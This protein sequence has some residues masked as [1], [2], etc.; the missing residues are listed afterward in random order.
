MDDTAGET[1]AS[2]DAAGTAVVCDSNPVNLRFLRAAVQKLGFEEVIV[3]KNVNE[4]V[5]QAVARQPQLVV[6]D[7][8]IHGGVGIDAIEP[9][10]R[11]VPGALV[12]AFCSD[13]ELAEA[14]RSMGL[15]T[16]A[17]A[18]MLQLDELVATVESRLGRAVAAQ[19]EDIPVTDMATPVWDLVPS[20]ANPDDEEP[21]P[22]E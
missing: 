15:V 7:P 22:N 20:L 11:E 17:K 5:A 3:T 8:A 19:A 9:L 18:S 10:A 4:L 16:V 21:R 6:F 12:V 14:V 2:R 1:R 13:A